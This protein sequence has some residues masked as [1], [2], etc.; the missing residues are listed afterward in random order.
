MIAGIDANDQPQLHQIDPSGMITLYKANSIGKNNKFVNEY[1]EKNYKD[2]MS[3]D[4]GLEM[5]AHCLSNNIDHPKKNSE[6]VVISKGN[7]RF[8]NS[9]EVSD[10]F[11]KI[12]S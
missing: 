2:N 1:L 8:L 7:I 12:E 4:E 10:L 3:L 11:K 6:I 5:V 9:Q